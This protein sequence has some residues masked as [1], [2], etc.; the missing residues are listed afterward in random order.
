[1][2]K[3][4][5]SFKDTLNS[6]KT[7][8]SILIEG[9]RE[10][11]NTFGD[12]SVNQI[13]IRQKSDSNHKYKSKCLSCGSTDHSRNDCRFRAVTCHNCKKIRTYC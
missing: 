10:Q 3:E 4:L 8:E 2:Q 1:M 9:T 12:S 13:K 7:I 11:A 6:V 5:T